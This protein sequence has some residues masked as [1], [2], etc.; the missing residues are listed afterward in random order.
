M[1]GLVELSLWP[2][3]LPVEI[4]RIS[5][6]QRLQ[7]LGLQHRQYILHENRPL[8]GCL[9]VLG[10]TKLDLSSSGFF[11]ATNHEALGQLAGPRTLTLNDSSHCDRIRGP[12]KLLTG[13]ERLEMRGV[14][15]A[16][17]F[18]GML[19]SLVRLRF[20]DLGRSGISL[21][22]DSISRLTL[23]EELLLDR[24]TSLVEVGGGIGALALLR[25][26]DLRECTALK[27]LPAG[28]GGLSALQQLLLSESGLE[29]LPEGIGG[30]Q[31]LGGLDLLGMP[32]LVDLPDDVSDL[33]SLHKM[34]IKVW[35]KLLFASVSASGA[36]FQQHIYTA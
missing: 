23:L 7:Y 1:T 16:H 2:D 29:A 5:V 20:L 13:L 22:P 14:T 4:D 6:L 9:P 27:K 36:R 31:S 25:I 10:L 35:S 8:P 34:I 3:L 30:L 24:C 17:G 32:S 12:I 11:N 33:V 26:L 21:V 28:I 19:V 18:G 15:W